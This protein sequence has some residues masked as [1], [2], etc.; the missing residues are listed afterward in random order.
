M[1]KMIASLAVLI[2]TFAIEANTHS[3]RFTR[4]WQITHSPN[5]AREGKEGYQ[6]TTRAIHLKRNASLTFRMRTTQSGSN[7]ELPLMTST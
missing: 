7:K 5:S 6:N 3:T 4:Y 1:T 2:N